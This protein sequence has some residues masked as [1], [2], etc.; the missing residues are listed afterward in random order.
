MPLTQKLSDL[1]TEVNAAIYRRFANSSFWIQAEITNVKKCAGK[2]RCFPKFIEKEGNL[3]STEIQGIFWSKAY[4]HTERF[5]QET[6]G[7]ALFAY[8]RP[9]GKTKEAEVK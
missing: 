3:V 8:A 5:E 2:R 4:F 6:I 1:I 9:V 7:V